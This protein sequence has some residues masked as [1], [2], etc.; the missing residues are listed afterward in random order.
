MRNGQ[1]EQERQL[2]QAIGRYTLLA[3]DAGAALAG[4]LAE[5][6]RSEL[7]CRA[8]DSKPGGVC[9]RQIQNMAEGY[10]PLHFA[11]LGPLSLWAPRAA[12]KML[13]HAVKL[14]GQ[15]MHPAPE[16]LADSPSLFEALSSIADSA[17]TSSEATAAAYAALHDGCLSLGELDEMEER[18]K[19]E[20]DKRAA[21][22]EQLRAM[23]QKP[24]VARLTRS[25]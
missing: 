5:E 13:A 10:S 25:S 20:D 14:I 19:R 8:V 23:A 1:G 16:Q 4:G 15:E 6:V 22:R 18:W 21:M 2:E 24:G 17:S 12:W 11:L 3:R 7:L 9:V